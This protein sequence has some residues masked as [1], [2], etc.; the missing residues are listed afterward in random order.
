MNFRKGFALPTI[1]IASVIML[2]VLLVTIAS[3]SSV[4]VSLANQYYE[5]LARSAAESG[6]AYARSC[7]DINNGTPIWNDSAPLKPNSDC[8]G[9]TASHPCATNFAEPICTV[10]TNGT[11][12]V[13]TFT[14]G[15]PETAADGRAISVLA[16]GKTLLLRSD[17]TVWREYSQTSKYAIM[18]IP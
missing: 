1:L 15:L 17:G 9:S 7:L 12:L 5:G 13:T 14:V 3:T 4:R 8:A 10:L 18:T 16:I 2:T 6:I 11:S